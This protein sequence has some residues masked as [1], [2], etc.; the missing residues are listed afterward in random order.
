[1]PGTTLLGPPL[2]IYTESTAIRRANFIHTIVYG[3]IPPPLYAPPESTT[4]S[5]DLTPWVNLAG[6]PAALVDEL[7]LRLMHGA[8][9]ADMRAR[10]IQAVGAMSEHA[11]TRAQAA[12]YLITTSAPYNVQR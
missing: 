7:S 8:M 6:D 10:I 2:Q 1:V 9:P 3:T 11:T 12:I 5:V 4:I